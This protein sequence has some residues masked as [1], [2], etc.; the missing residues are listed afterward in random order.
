MAAKPHSPGASPVPLTD[1][2]LLELRDARHCRPSTGRQRA[3]A[4]TG[5]FVRHAR[6]QTVPGIAGAEVIVTGMGKS[7]QHI[8][9]KIAATLSSIRDARLLSAS[10]RSQPRRHWCD[11]A[12]GR[13]AGDFNSGETA[14]IVTL[15]PHIRRLGV[16]LITMTGRMRRT[17]P[18][19]ALRPSVSRRE[20][21][22]RSLPAQSRALLQAQPQRLRWG[23]DRGRGAQAS[24]FH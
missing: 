19:R 8:A 5:R 15:V 20:R 13:A 17:Q 11:H 23:C 3:R 24:W 16:A 14:E 21:S 9:G 4:A 22:A 12:P 1:D 2:A 10:C 18:W 6:L 7:G